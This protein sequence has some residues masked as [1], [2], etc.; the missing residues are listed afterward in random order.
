MSFS[1]DMPR[2]RDEPTGF[3]I[4]MFRASPSARASASAASGCAARCA[5]RASSRQRAKAS[6]KATYSL[7]STVGSTVGSIVGSILGSILGSIVGSTLG[8]TCSYLGQHEGE[9]HQ[10]KGAAARV[11]A[12]QVLLEQ[13]FA[14]ELPRLRRASGGRHSKGVAARRGVAA[15]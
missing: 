10:V 15:R 9:R 3:R 14:C 6:A 7:G 13:V 12:L 5:A 11:A 1:S 8:S 4:Q 2:P